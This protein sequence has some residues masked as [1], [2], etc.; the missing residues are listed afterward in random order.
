M[1]LP[2][3]AITVAPTGNT[4]EIAIGI[5]GVGVPM[6]VFYAIDKLNVVDPWTV[7]P[8]FNGPGFYLIKGLN[9]YQ[10][11]DFLVMALRTGDPASL[12]SN[13]GKVQPLPYLPYFSVEL[14]R[15]D[16]PDPVDGRTY[17]FRTRIES[18]LPK[19]MAQEIFLYRRESFSGTQVLARDV[20]VAV[21]KIGDLTLYP[22]NTPVAGSP[23]FRLSYVDFKERSEDAPFVIWDAIYEDVAEL[24]KVL[25]IDR[26]YA[27]GEVV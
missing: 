26:D 18:R 22:A 8:T 14:Y 1:S 25:G 6:Q 5:G 9:D 27:S 23:Y 7:G 24:V 10:W 2:S 21:C 4:G 15:Q 11:Y 12:P 16:Q 17:L 19:N 13:I 3:P 20:F